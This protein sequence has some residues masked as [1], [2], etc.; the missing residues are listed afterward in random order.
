MA[1]QYDFHHKLR[2]GWPA[3]VPLLPRSRRA[4][5]EIGSRRN[6]WHGVCGPEPRET[7]REPFCTS[8]IRE[9]A[10][11]VP[12]EAAPPSRMLHRSEPVA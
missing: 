11:Q 3:T 8:A 6:V 1:I 10:P 7:L 4:E 9:W 12:F 5:P 2:A